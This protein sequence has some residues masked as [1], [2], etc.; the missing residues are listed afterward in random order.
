MINDPCHRKSNEAC[1]CE[2]T[3]LRIKRLGQRKWER[4]RQKYGF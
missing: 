1:A 2:V 4:Y 3:V